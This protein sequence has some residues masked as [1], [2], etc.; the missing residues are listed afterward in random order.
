MRILTV[1]GARPQFIKSAIISNQIIDST[2]LEEIVVHTG[3]HFEH[4]MSDIFFQEMN[5]SKPNYNLGINRMNR[6]LMIEKM[7]EKL[8]PILISEKP[9]AVLVYGDTNSTLA[10]SLAA[11][12]LKIP[13]FHIESGLRSFNKSMPEELNRVKTDQLSSLLFCPTENSVNN[14]TKEGITEGVFLSGDVMYDIFRMFSRKNKNFSKTKLQIKSDYVVTTI[15]RQENTDDE[16]KLRS[17]FLNLDMINEEIKVVLPLH[18][19]TKGQLQ[20]FNI[21]TNIE[22][23][24]PLGYLSMLSL[25]KSAEMV[26][27][28][29]GGLQKE[30][31]FAEKKCITVREE[32]E[33]KELIDNDIN[34]LSNPDNL[35]KKFESMRKNDCN[36]PKGL[37]GDGNA[38][39]IILDSII[40]YFD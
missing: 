33:W 4:N 28:D 10:G 30:A 18:P 35:F 7:I 25:I 9:D 27:T 5:L 17:I 26:I 19:R 2:F 36:F 37:Y 24:D 39:E 31:F 40:R 29:S 3:Q 32:T 11:E 6:E 8:C 23:I 22:C 12:K 38:S 16:E 1:L 34:N 20:R 14:L 21:K 15:H 13:I